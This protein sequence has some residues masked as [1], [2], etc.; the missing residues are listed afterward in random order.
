MRALGEPDAFP[1]SDLGLLRAMGLKNSRE[2]EK[3]AE[4]WRPWR[5]YGAMYLWKIGS[6]AAGG[7]NKLRSSIQKMGTEGTAPQQVPMSL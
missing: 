4:A 6:Q 2:L 5:A 3:R 1:S 7:G